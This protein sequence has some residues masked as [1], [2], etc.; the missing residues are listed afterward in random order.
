MYLRNVKQILRA[1]DPGFD[2]RRYGFGGLMDLLRACQ[3]EDYIRLER[4]RRGG[5]RVFQG[6]ALPRASALAP[7]P[8]DAFESQPIEEGLRES[9]QPSDPT[10]SDL[11]DTEPMPTVD[12]TAELLGRA[13]ARRPRTRLSAMPVS[14]APP[15][16]AR[17]RKSAARPATAMAKAKTTKGRSMPRSKKAAAADAKDHPDS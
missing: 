3:R 9:A 10:E 1:A 13:K 11:I 17:A 8:T 14:A 4:D 7:Q 5:L 12:P 2:E 15:R 16:A 6:T